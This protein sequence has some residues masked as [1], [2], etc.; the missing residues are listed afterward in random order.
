MT[1]KIDPEKETAREAE[2]EHELQF[3]PAS[4]DFNG[5]EKIN[6]FFT[7]FIRKAEDGKGHLEATFQGRPLDGEVIDLK[8]K[9][10]EAVVLQSGVAM[11]N[12][13]EDKSVRVIKRTEKLTYWN[14]DRIPS[15]QD[16][17]QQA[18][19]YVQLAKAFHD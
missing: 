3:I 12:A 5:S 2:S 9:G 10:L 19:N 1:T 11:N 13:A 7:K 17:F 6:D 4:I 8:S 14:Y 18:L 16:R 15:E